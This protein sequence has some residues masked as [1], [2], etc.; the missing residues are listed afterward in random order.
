MGTQ[1]VAAASYGVRRRATTDGSCDAGDVTAVDKCVAE[2]INASTG[3]QVVAAV[4]TES[5]TAKHTTATAIS[6]QAIHFGAHHEHSDE[7]V[8]ELGTGGLGKNHHEGRN[9][10]A[11]FNRWNISS[12]DSDD[13]DLRADAALDDSTSSQVASTAPLVPFLSHEPVEHIEPSPSFLDHSK[14][15]SK[16]NPASPASPLSA[17]TPE[18]S[19]FPAQQN[20]HIPAAPE[21]SL[22]VS[23]APEPPLFIFTANH[24]TS[25]IASTFLPAP[26]HLL[27]PTHKY[28]RA[29]ESR[30]SH[31]SP[32]TRQTLS[33][34]TLPRARR[35]SMEQRLF[36]SPPQEQL[37]N[38]SEMVEEHDEDNGGDGN[39]AMLGGMVEAGKDD[40]V[41][42]AR[43]EDHSGASASQ[44]H[45]GA[46]ASQATDTV[47]MNFKKISL[48]S[49]I[50]RDIVIKGGQ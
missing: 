22:H 17:T 26:S 44:D 23:A 13:D 1:A 5:E 38:A 47:M 48:E 49:M 14:A 28:G 11:F 37:V 9:G 36:A 50:K 40:S 46:S 6:E 27:P 18:A 12:S 34:N 20:D 2:G 24:L 10:D 29:R 31:H 8:S 35:S 32:L 4:E 41:M 25:E 21:L 19:S 33:S 3:S 7:P 15:S 30:G 42:V 45:R 39:L 43:A 16:S